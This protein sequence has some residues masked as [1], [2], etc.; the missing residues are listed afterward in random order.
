MKY[1]TKT[2]LKNT[3]PY[4]K[5]PPDISPKAKHRLKWMDYIRKGN[6]IAKCARHFD[7]P[8][9]TIR[10]W[11]KKYIPYKPH[12]LQDVSKKPKRVRYSQVPLRNHK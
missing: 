7:I 12:T 4:I 3:L 2:T 8:E 1:D 11:Y 5:L 10:Y 9:S 6:S